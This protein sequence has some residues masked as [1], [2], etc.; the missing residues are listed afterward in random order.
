MTEREICISY[1]EAK[2][3][4]EQTKI[5]AELNGTDRFEIIRILIKNDVKLASSTIKYMHKRLEQLD[6]NIS[7][8][9]RE[10]HKI[11]DLLNMVKA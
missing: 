1:K 11:V 10:Y 3:P 7:K 8:G 4:N 5:L 6:A 9:E 2:Q